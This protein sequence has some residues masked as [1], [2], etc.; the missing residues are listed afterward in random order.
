MHAH[1]YVIIPQANQNHLPRARILQGGGGDSAPLR[2]Q[3]IYINERIELYYIDYMYSYF[4]AQQ[5]RLQVII[6][7]G[8][9]SFSSSHRI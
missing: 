6:F 9:L 5:K 3:S 1:L 8:P 2:I 7:F 4:F